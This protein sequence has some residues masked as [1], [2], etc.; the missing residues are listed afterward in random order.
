M[1]QA[2]SD[3]IRRSRWLGYS[4]VAF[5][6]VPFALWG[7]QAYFTGPGDQV[8]AEVNGVEIPMHLFDQQV[9]ERRQ[10]L[11]AQF[12]GDLPEGLDETVIRQQV[13]EELIDRELLAIAAT[14]L[15]LR[16]S[17]AAVAERIRQQPFFQRDG[18]FDANLYHEI[19]RRSGIRPADYEADM[20]RNE[21]LSQLR[22][23]LLDS[24]FILPGEGSFIAALDLQER[25]ISILRL[26]REAAE[27]NVEIDDEALQ[28]HY[29]THSDRYVTPERV[30][31]SYLEL[32]REGMKA[33]VAL[34][35]SVVDRAVE[36]R[37]D[38]LRGEQRR[39]AAHILIEHTE[40]HDAG[41]IV[42]ELRHRIVSEGEDFHDVARKHSEDI[43][44]AADGGR[45]GLVSPGDMVGPF[46]DA[47][48]D[49]ESAGDISEPVRTQYGY[50]LIKLLGIDAEETLS[51][52]DIRDQVEDELRA[53]RV[54]D[55]FHDRADAMI[56]AA[57][58]NPSSLEP[59]A[60]V[61]GV[62][63]RDSEWFSRDDGDGIAEF[64][65][66]REA[67]FSE[68]VLVEGMNSDPVELDDGRVVVLRVMDHRE[69]EPLGLAE[70]EEDVRAELVAMRTD[71]ILAEWIGTLD[72][73]LDEG[74]EDIDAFA[75]AQDIPVI[76][77]G[78]FRI[79][80]IG[81]EWHEV[82]P[83]V[84]R[85]TFTLDPPHAD[86]PHV[87]ERT[88][89]IDGDEAIVLLHDVEY[90]DPQPQDVAE[91]RAMLD[92]LRAES[93][94]EAWISALRAE[95]SIDINRRAVE[96]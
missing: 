96:R 63:L 50:H 90:P 13:L 19:L 18:R 1:L 59:A 60:D 43:G 37:Q 6:S 36:R 17:D 45:L 20:R 11:R 77:Q 69:P 53:R 2:F 28:A 92:G 7:I 38:E 56:G 10:Q 14:E 39:E 85:T 87:H 51:R 25:E 79:R 24:A 32:D 54:D 76:R 21:R 86:V 30:R 55:I 34:D 41:K 83:E 48:F 82:G 88:R 73:A 91:I 47:L 68:T 89:L 61:S 78:P 12:N 67:A 44:S 3:R 42:G 35:E 16:A 57:Y 81:D 46:D 75:E 49:L 8:A 15:G 5:I 95:A 84:R 62:E 65:G 71:R 23:G 80:L 22:R 31:I 64:A 27:R 72:R 29:E 40:D 94:F 74:I 4:I 33:A 93:E 9:A 26:E 70:V 66:I 58:E 52:D